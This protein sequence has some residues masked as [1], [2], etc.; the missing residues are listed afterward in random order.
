MP[1]SALQFSLEMG[2]KSE[3]G[4][5]HVC[6]KMFAII[7]SDDAASVS[8][9]EIGTRQEDRQYHRK[10]KLSDGTTCIYSSYV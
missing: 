1:V 10:K 5:L 6:D 8:K 2:S 9:G 3:G 7:G 4:C